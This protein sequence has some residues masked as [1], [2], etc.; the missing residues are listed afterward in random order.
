MLNYCIYIYI[1]VAVEY[2]TM[3]KRRD[4]EMENEVNALR[5]EVTMLKRER[6]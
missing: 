1:Y 4:F 6:G 5:R 2:I 3:L